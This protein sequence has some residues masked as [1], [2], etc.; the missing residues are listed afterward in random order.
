M[1]AAT[2]NKTMQQAS[3]SVGE[4]CVWH[5]ILGTVTSKSEL[6]E[7]AFEQLQG[8]VQDQFKAAIALAD[9]L[10][11]DLRQRSQRIIRAWA[12]QDAAHEA[13]CIVARQEKKS[14]RERELALLRN[15]PQN[16]SSTRKRAQA[17]SSSGGTGKRRV[18]TRSDLSSTDGNDNSATERVSDQS[19]SVEDT[20]RHPSGCKNIRGTKGLC[21]KHGGNTRCKHASG[22]EKGSVKKGLCV[23]HGG[24]RICEYKGGCDRSKKHKNLCAGH[25]P[26][27]LI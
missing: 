18:A 16:S 7:L 14:K 12:A 8:S 26:P 13:A 21:E 6:H 11:T 27:M 25:A 3:T 19:S 9:S 23:S 15:A 24:R 22:C 4:D 20:C 1:V 17:S 2:V 10:P 5:E